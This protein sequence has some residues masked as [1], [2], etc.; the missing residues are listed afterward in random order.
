MTTGA[1]SSGV[2]ATTSAMSATAPVLSLAVSLYPFHDENYLLVNLFILAPCLFQIILG[3]FQNGIIATRDDYQSVLEEISNMECRI[4]VYR[5]KVKETMH[6]EV[7]LI[8]VHRSMKTTYACLTSVLTNLMNISSDAYLDCMIHELCRI[9]RLFRRYITELT[10]DMTS[11]HNSATSSTVKL[12]EL[13][14][15][16]LQPVL[17]F[18]P[19]SHANPGRHNLVRVYQDEILFRG[20]L[21]SNLDFS[22]KLNQLRKLRGELVRLDNED[23]GSSTFRMSLHHL[24]E[25][26]LRKSEIMVKHAKRA[27]SQNLH[28]NI[29]VFHDDYT[30]AMRQL[31]REMIYRM[32]HH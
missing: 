1:I 31:N 17:K 27:K 13:F 10:C 20:G 6:H 19:T 24:L 4:P 11:R 3:K 8:K 7:A 26:I 29:Q 23:V 25:A 22:T 2:Y 18:F 12:H 16:L 21:I 28:V 15:E 14:P 5:L 9:T 30:Y 32:H